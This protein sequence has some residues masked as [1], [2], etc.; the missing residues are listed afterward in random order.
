MAPRRGGGS[1][2]GSSSI[3]CSDY[4]FDSENSRVS[5]AF[6]ALFFVVA[7]ALTIIGS[8]KAKR[9]KQIGRPLV[10]W[11]WL[12]FSIIFSLVSQ[13]IAIVLAVLRECAVFYSDD[14]FP[15]WIVSSWVSVFSTFILNAVILISFSKKLH[16]EF[17]KG[18]ATILGVQKGYVIILLVL[19]LTCLALYTASSVAAYTA[20]Y[21]SDRYETLY[22]DLVDPQKGIWTT[23]YTLSVLGILIASATIIKSIFGGS[24]Y[25]H[26]GKL[27]GWVSAL[28]IGA[29]GFNVVDLANYVYITFQDTTFLTTSE[30][31]EIEKRSLVTYFLTSF[32][33][34]VAF[35]A[36]LQ[37]GAY[38][39]QTVVANPAYTVPV[40]QHNPVYPQQHDYRFNSGYNSGF[41]SHPQHP[42]NPGYPA[43]R[44]YQSNNIEYQAR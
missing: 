27:T 26:P 19:A 17:G 8:R 43:D 20:D 9:A 22:A 5:I 39:A 15:G 36:A 16:T 28:L 25:S 30:A 41:T 38:G 37:V 42:A 34:F 40:S 33:Y 44:A 12:S 1:S 11:G 18:S 2:W 21:Y 4:A 35:Y 31:E 3:S 7:L 29:L 14:I 23:Y 10:A 6:Q 13:I 24:G 32:F